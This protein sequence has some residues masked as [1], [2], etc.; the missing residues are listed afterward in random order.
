MCRCRRKTLLAF[1]IVSKFKYCVSGVKLTCCLKCQVTNVPLCIYQF[2][3]KGNV[4]SEPLRQRVPRNT[5]WIP[6]VWTV[7]RRLIV[8]RPHYVYWRAHVIGAFSSLVLSFFDFWPI[9]NTSLCI[10]QLPNQIQALQCIFISAK[11]ECREWIFKDRK[12][13]ILWTRICS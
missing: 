3:Y 10:K 6:L 8:L 12:L 4:L 1:Q 11:V 7:G 2:Y 5:F 13:F 9:R